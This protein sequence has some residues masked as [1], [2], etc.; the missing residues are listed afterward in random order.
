MDPVTM[1][2]PSGHRHVLQNWAEPDSTGAE[3]LNLSEFG[4]HAGNFAALKVVRI[5]DHRRVDERGGD[6]GFLKAINYDEIDS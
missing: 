3:C 6:F 1:I 4:L 2:A 5:P